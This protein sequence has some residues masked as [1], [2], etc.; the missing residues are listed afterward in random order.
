MYRKLDLRIIITME[1]ELLKSERYQVGTYLM[2]TAGSQS[3]FP[4]LPYFVDLNGHHGQ[5]TNVFEL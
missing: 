5:S 4:T 1:T 3:N 2:E